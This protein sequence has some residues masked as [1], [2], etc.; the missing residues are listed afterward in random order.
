MHAAGLL[1]MIRTHRRNIEEVGFGCQC[2]GHFLLDRHE[3]GWLSGFFWVS[4]IVVRVPEPADSPG[5]RGFPLQ[6]PSQCRGLASEQNRA[7]RGRIDGPRCQQHTVANGCNRLSSDEKIQYHS[8]K[9]L[10]LQI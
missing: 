2:R 7:T 5:E 8:L 1:T 4:A 3:P 9:L 6:R 10:A